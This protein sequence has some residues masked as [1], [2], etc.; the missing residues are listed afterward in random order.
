MAWA[1]GKSK[2][3][4]YGH[5]WAWK[6]LRVQ[7]WARLENDFLW[8]GIKLNFIFP[9]KWK[10]IC[11]GLCQ[12]YNVVEKTWIC[13]FDFSLNSAA[14]KLAV[15]KCEVIVNKFNGKRFC[16]VEYCKC[17]N[18]VFAFETVLNGNLFGTDPNIHTV[19]GPSIC[20]KGGRYTNT[21]LR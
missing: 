8:W 11:Y 10:K 14:T 7:I 2:W 18:K 17:G 16:H 5:L 13:A 1:I 6:T 21:E 12:F 4:I 19:S 3:A 9:L 20:L 15:P